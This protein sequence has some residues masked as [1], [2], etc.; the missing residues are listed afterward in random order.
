MECFGCRSSSSLGYHVAQVTKTILLV[1]SVAAIA[2]MTYSMI[3]ATVGSQQFYIQ[4]GI[5]GASLLS[6]I[7]LSVSIAKACIE[8]RKRVSAADASRGDGTGDAARGAGGPAGDASSGDGAGDV[9]RRARGPAGDASLGDGAGDAARGAGGPAVDASSGDGAVDDARR[10]RGPAGDASLG[11]GAGDVARGAR[12]PAVDASRGD[13]AGDD[14]SIEEDASIEDGA[15]AGEEPEAHRSLSGS[16]IQSPKLPPLPSS[17]PPE[18]KQQLDRPPVARSRAA[19]HP[20]PVTPPPPRSVTPARGVPAAVAARSISPAPSSEDDDANDPPA[21]GGMLRGSDLGAAA[22]LSLPRGAQD[23]AASGVVVLPALGDAA[24]GVRFMPRLTTDS[25]SDEEGSDPRAPVIAASGR[26]ERSASASLIG[27]R[28][29]LRTSSVPPVLADRDVV[30]LVRPVAVAARGAPAPMSAPPDAASAPEVITL[31]ADIEQ[32]DPAFYQGWSGLAAQA[33]GQVVGGWVSA[34]AADAVINPGSLARRAYVVA[35]LPLVEAVLLESG[36]RAGDILHW[37]EREKFEQLNQILVGARRLVHLM[38]GAGDMPEHFLAMLRSLV[39]MGSAEA[40]TFVMRKEFFALLD[41][42][43]ASE[44]Y[45]SY[46]RGDIAATPMIKFFQNF[47]RIIYTDTNLFPFACE[48]FA[49]ATK[50][51][52]AEVDYTTT[53]LATILGDDRVC[54]ENAGDVLLGTAKSRRGMKSKGTFNAGFNPTHENNVPFPLFRAK[55]RIRG[56]DRDVE[57]IR[58]GSPTSEVAYDKPALII[59]VFRLYLDWCKANNKT[60]LSFQ[61]Q[62]PERK[63][64]K[65]GEWHRL[66]AVLDLAQ[67]PRYAGVIRVICIPF[68]GTFFKQKADGDQAAEAFL[69]EFKRQIRLRTTGPHGL[70]KEA[71]YHFPVDQIGALDAIIDRV[72]RLFFDAKAA[73]SQDERQVFLMIAHALFQEHFIALFKPDFF[74]SQCKDAQDRALS[75]IAT[76][77]FINL[78]RLEKHTDPEELNNFRVLIVAFT[79]LVNKG[80]GMHGE[81]FERLQ[82]VVDH[83]QNFTKRPGWHQRLCAE[84]F[85]EGV[86]FLGSTY[87]RSEGAGFWPHPADAHTAEEYDRLMMEREVLLVEHEVTMEWDWGYFRGQG[88]RQAELDFTRNQYFING[89]RLAVSEKLR[90]KLEAA[91]TDRTLIAAIVQL[92]EGHRHPTEFHQGLANLRDR[93]QRFAR[94]I[95][96]DVMEI[97]STAKE[98]A[99]EEAL[100]VFGEQAPLL[101]A[102]ATQA[103]L[104]VAMPVLYQRYGNADVGRVLY[105]HCT[106]M[107]IQP[108]LFNIAQQEGDKIV[109]EILHLSPIGPGEAQPPRFNLESRLCLNVTDGTAHFSW[110]YSD[111]R[112]RYPQSYNLLRCRGVD[113]AEDNPLDG[114]GVFV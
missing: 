86:E 43:Y 36:F 114:S 72:Y 91:E 97:Y 44:H 41:T 57:C 98:E 11:D 54:I 104:G 32:S 100:G 101:K 17:V 59:P 105:G 14:A 93:D 37:S 23:M 26:G 66:K 106:E 47:G 63:A 53:P 16:L 5:A 74:H 95:V 22:P 20:A 38:E 80:M 13:G 70:G 75:M 111:A 112:G 51:Q 15:G 109:V 18:F 55:Y 113:G 103:S 58:F 64:V 27:S 67:E 90:A 45:Q 30:P 39:R 24:Q 31:P 99:Y 33:A 8:E 2:F 107:L 96:A 84:P 94:M 10:A 49:A 46:L 110:E 3:H 76:M 77:E 12:S 60:L 7:L 92:E 108:T 25:D 42:T 89:K 68:D 82:K 88:A 29:P 62:N 65:E 78:M 34:A 4:A 81:R 73:L 35:M 19:V 48:S 79:A 28:N 9:A 102:L 50:D 87:P 6:A 1:A 21:I 85:V 61:H 56:E 52:R 40:D 69:Q 83:L 71:R